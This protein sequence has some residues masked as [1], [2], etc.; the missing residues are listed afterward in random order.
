[1]DNNTYTL[2]YTDKSSLR[3]MLSISQECDNCGKCAQAC[4]FGALKITEE[5][6]IMF[7]SLSCVY[8]CEV[9]ALV[10]EKKAIKGVGRCRWQPEERRKKW[11]TIL[12]TKLPIHARIIAKIARLTV[13]KKNKK[14]K[15]NKK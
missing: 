2:T 11:P 3:K 13:Q 10:C 9:C 14:P 1:M 8:E 5:G 12:R 6:D 7:R 15:L 4:P